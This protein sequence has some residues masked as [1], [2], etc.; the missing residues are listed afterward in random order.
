MS[1]SFR[2]VSRGFSAV[3]VLGMAL[4]TS[5]GAQ[6]AGGDAAIARELDSYIRRGMK[7]W[8]IPGL[9][10]AVVHKDSVV[11]LRGYGVLQRGSPQPV[12]EHTLF[13]MMSTTKAMTAMAIAMLVDDGKLRWD[14]PVTRWV[15]EFAMPDPWLTRELR[16]QDLLT[17]NAGLG[18]ADLL[19]SRHDLTAEEIFQRVRLLKQ[20][21]PLRGGFVYQNVMYGL[22]GEVVARASGMPYVEFLRRRLFAPLGMTGTYPSYA[23]MIASGD[24]NVSRPHYRIRDTIRVI[25][26]EAVDVIPA[27]GAVWS[28]A[29]DMSAWV[30]FLLDSA[31]SG[32]RR[33]VSDSNFRRLFEP[34]ALIGPDEFYP[35]ARL[36]QP[37]WTSYGLGW[38]EQDYRG[39]FVAFHTGSLDGRTA[40]IGLLPDVQAGVYVFGNLDHAEFRHA[41]MLKVFDLFLGGPSRDWN[42]ELLRLYAGLRARSDSARAVQDRQQIPGTHPSHPLGAYAGTY[43]HPIWGR[44]VVEQ[45]GD[46][47]VLSIGT[48]PQLRGPLRHWHYDSFRAELGDG[49]ESPDLVQFGVGTDG[50]VTELRLAGIEGVFGREK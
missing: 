2:L 47:L 37:H 1:S 31:E 41:L 4:A 21:Y 19:W 44:V 7:D 43:S 16:V 32:G 38:F 50:Q 5:A 3:A 14:D 34:Q 49:R 27:A 24:D 36:T 26:D 29:A 33:L 17:H 46:G 28:T 11:L 15:P 8:E 30:T 35:T 48:N 25:E 10:V 6:R 40:I 23:A 12:D 20:A 45:V 22:A 18:N 39:H 9:S 42:G 13:G